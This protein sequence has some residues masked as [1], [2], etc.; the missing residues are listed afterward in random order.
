M[1]ELA[2]FL[3][4]L[5]SNPLLMNPLRFAPESTGHLMNFVDFGDSGIRLNCKRRCLLFTWAHQADLF[6]APSVFNEPFLIGLEQF[7]YLLTNQIR[8]F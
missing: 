6:A 2:A 7:I 1:E 5:R 4:D 8:A 3:A